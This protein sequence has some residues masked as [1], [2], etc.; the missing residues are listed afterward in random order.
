MNKFLLNVFIL[1]KKKPRL[2]GYANAEGCRTDTERI[3][4]RERNG[5]RT[6]MERIRNGNGLKKN[7]NS[8]R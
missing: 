2:T 7:E 4:E 6:E 8:V 1:R 3:R 5:D